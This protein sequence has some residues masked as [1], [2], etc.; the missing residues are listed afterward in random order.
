MELPD[1]VHDLVF[2]G[3]CDDAQG[4]HGGRAADFAIIRTLLGEALEHALGNFAVAVAR[5]GV[6]SLVRVIRERVSQATYGFVVHEVDGIA[7]V[8]FGAGRAT[9][10]VLPGPHQR[11]LQNWK[12]VRVVTDL[13]QQAVHQTD[14]NTATAYAHGIGNG[15]TALLAR[16]A[17][18]QVHARRDVFRQVREARAVSDKIRA[19]GD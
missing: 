13:V 18:N 2:R 7:L 10:P 12:L 19:H 17:W 9:H 6:V 11:V 3:A 16:H 1:D 15:A 4:R 14:R 8:R 5:Q